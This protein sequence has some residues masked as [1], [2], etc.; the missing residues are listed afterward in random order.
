MESLPGINDASSNQE[1]VNG[2][3]EIHDLSLKKGDEWKIGVSSDNKLIV[4]IIHGIAEIFGTELANN[5]DYVF[6]NFKFSI[7]AV[8]D[9]EL[10]WR[11]MELVGTNLSVQENITAKYIYNLHF[12]LEKLRAAS[13]DG[14]KIMIVGNS[15]TGKTSL[16]RTL[17]S[18][19]IKY[20]TYQPLF[21]N[22]NP[23]EGIFTV[24]GAISA[25]PV[26]DILDPQSSRWGQSMTSGATELHSK[27]PLV[28]NFGLEYIRENRE[29]YKVVISQLAEVAMNRMQNDALVH[30]SGCI[31]N[32]PPL[33]DLDD[34]LSELLVSFNQFKVNY[35]IYL[36]E[37]TDENFS[38]IKKMFPESFLA[39]I[40]RIP[41]LSGIIPTDDIYKRSLQRSS[42]REYFYGTYNSVLSPYT[43]GVDFDDLTVWKPKN[44]IEDQENMEQ[45]SPSK[46]T[47]VE[48]NASN[49]QH[50]L[51]S[52][53]YADRKENESAVQKAAI[54]GYGLV[55][56]VNEKR[57]KLRILLPVPGALP[58]KAMVLTSY[59][60][61]E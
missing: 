49:L 57:H 55:T 19:A 61:L 1:V 3:D 48:I 25:T 28:K 6:Q 38:K 7:F 56:E 24:P 46:Y 8:E 13:F 39:N 4:K 34:D 59:R 45:S 11:C 37:E 18:Y 60:Y 53:T 20:K 41:K 9:V 31:I 58:N 10:Q 52:L 26:S 22:L 47:S 40:L 42:I 21:V 5:K 2:D 29:L 54:L 16:T 17:C 30:R 33:E 12:A 32:T 36:G 15:N 50:S 27:Q 44:M 51:V 14:P 23:A 35:I 43:I